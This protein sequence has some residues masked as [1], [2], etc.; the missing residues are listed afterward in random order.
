[1]YVS[2]RCHIFLLVFA[3]SIS[4]AFSF[5]QPA[6]TAGS[7]HYGIY[8]N[9]KAVGEGDYTVQATA[10]GYSV[11]SHGKLN[12]TK[13]SYSFNNS[14]NLD[15]SLNLI[16]DELSGTVN[17][18]AVSFTAAADSTGRQFEI[19][20]SANGKQ[21]QNTVDRHQHLVF[22]P[23]LD[24]AAY[25]LATRVVMENP[26][27]SWIL[28]PKQ[29]GILVPSTITPGSSPGSGVRGQLNGAQ[30]QVQY[31]RL[32]VNSENSIDVDLFYT[33]DGQVLEADLPQ[34]NFSVVHDGFKLLE[35]PKP[36]AS[37]APAQ[38]GNR[39]GNATPQYPAPQGGAPQP[40]QQ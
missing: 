1:M 11:K 10:S 22:L 30:I 40:Q 6:L 29:D 14:Q 2:A 25:L 18:S 24:P 8:Q 28:I 16:R 13:F 38:S 20:V 15:G 3:L 27:T 35:H 34:Q 37:P 32:A 7:A 23:D 36:P 26:P 31:A 39:P 17:G 9:G 21:T 5:G 33:A 19:S 4:A 12:L